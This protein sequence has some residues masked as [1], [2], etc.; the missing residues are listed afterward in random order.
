MRQYA[1]YMDLALIFFFLWQVTLSATYHISPYTS[2]ASF[3]AKN[4]WCIHADIYC[5]PSIK[6]FEL[7]EGYREENP[8][9]IKEYFRTSKEKTVLVL[10]MG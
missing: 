1:R 10:T 5:M 9:W 7:Q 6:P 8:P 3:R 4:P 2:I